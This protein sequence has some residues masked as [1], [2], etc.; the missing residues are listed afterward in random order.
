M[1]IEFGFAFSPFVWAIGVLIADD[2]RT[3][4]FYPVPMLSIYFRVKG[5]RS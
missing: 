4:Y 3:V 2:R 1:T 5:R